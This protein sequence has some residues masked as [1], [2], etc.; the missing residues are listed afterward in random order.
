METPVAIDPSFKI[1]GEDRWRHKFDVIDSR[2]TKVTMGIQQNNKAVR[3]SDVKTIDNI[4]T[5]GR[6][7]S[8]RL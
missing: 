2:I 8:K 5:V 3:K 7:V 4:F 1:P 6:K